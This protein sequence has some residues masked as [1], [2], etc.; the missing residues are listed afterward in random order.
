[1]TCFGADRRCGR[2]R[3]TSVSRRLYPDPDVYPVSKATGVKAA[4]AEIVT[5]PAFEVTVTVL[6]IVE[7]VVVVAVSVSVDCSVTML[8][9]VSVTAATVVVVVAVCVTVTEVVHGF[10][11]MVTVGVTVV[12]FLCVRVKVSEYLYVGTRFVGHGAWTVLQKA[13]LLTQSF[14]LSVAW[15]MPAPD[16]AKA[17]RMDS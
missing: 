11:V 6:E 13:V 7:T 2:L 16:R 15:T 9:I 3:A 1:M 14:L 5:V 12:V 4:E 10:G 17:T 8:V